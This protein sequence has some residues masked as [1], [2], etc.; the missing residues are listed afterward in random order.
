MVIVVAKPT[1]TLFPWGP[2]LMTSNG[3]APITSESPRLSSAVTFASSTI[4]PRDAKHENDVILTGI[5]ERAVAGIVGD[6]I[7]L[8]RVA[9]LYCTGA[10]FYC[11]H[12]ELLGCCHWRQ[13]RQDRRCPLDDVA[14]DRSVR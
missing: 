3:S 4:A 2:R 13:R 6:A 7:V 12:L 9:S 1:T 8:R 11:A 10:S 14:G 5:A